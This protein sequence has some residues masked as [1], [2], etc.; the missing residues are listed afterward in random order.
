M[1]ILEYSWHRP[2]FFCA[3]MKQRKLKLFFSDPQQLFTQVF[4]TGVDDLGVLP[5]QGYDDFDIEI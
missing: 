2:T 5:R 1:E 3:F 4:F